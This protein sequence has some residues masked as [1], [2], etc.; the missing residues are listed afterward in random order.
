[1]TAQLLR[2]LTKPLLMPVLA[3]SFTSST[4]GRRDVLRQATLGAQALSWG[5]DL[6]L[7]G[8]SERA[9]LTGVGSFLAAHVSYIAGFASAGLGP[10]G[11]GGSADAGS[12]GSG[13]I[14]SGPSE[15]GVGER[16]VTDG[17]NT[18]PARRGTTGLK[19]AAA[20]WTLTAP[21][22][23]FAAGRKDPAM[24]IPIAAYATALATMFATSTLLDPGM[25]RRHR[26]KIVLGTSLFLL[27]D[28]ILGVQEFLLEESSPALES[29]VMATYAAGQWFIADGVAGSVTT[30]TMP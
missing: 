7:L 13:P 11:S 18:T 10:R 6:A 26:R 16:G 24:R 23:A 21:P 2:Y 3:T 27:S 22:M 30:A 8:K 15:R 5:G 12:I 20:L 1:V 9:F 17:G 4:D 14:G 25:P 28:T 19:S 29:A